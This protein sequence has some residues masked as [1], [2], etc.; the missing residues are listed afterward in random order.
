MIMNRKGFVLAIVMVLLIV[1]AITSLGLYNAVYFVG[2]TQGIDE[3]RRI[4]GYYAASAGLSYASVLLMRENPVFSNFGNLFSI[5]TQLPADFGFTG[6]EDVKIKITTHLVTDNSVPKIKKIGGYHVTSTYT[7]LA[8]E[9]KV[10]GFVSK[11][12]FPKTGQTITYSN[13][14]DGYY[15]IGAPASGPLLQDNPRYTDNLDDT[16]TD[17]TTGLMWVKDPSLCGGNTYPNPWA[18][19]E[20]TPE[21]MTWADA[22]TNCEALSYAG[23]NDWR[24]PNIKE[25]MSIVDF[26]KSMPAIDPIFTYSVY[27]YNYNLH[28][29]CWSSTNYAA[30][31]GARWCVD[32]DGG[33]VKSSGMGVMY[34]ARAVRGGQ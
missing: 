29:S 10:A 22:I 28:Y 32:F 9:I 2:K 7:F 4:R 26:G 19:E 33:Y 18:S 20:D 31:T 1:I 8:E 14:D 6:S 23:H 24:L 21:I 3:V 15:Q 13:F 17:N 34:Y 25:L 16:I 11:Y 30:F 5:K 12:G 27:Y